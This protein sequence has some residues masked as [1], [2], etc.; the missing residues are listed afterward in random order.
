MF[1]SGGRLKRRAVLLVTVITLLIAGLAM[2]KMACK[3]LFGQINRNYLD[4]RGMQ[5]SYHEL[6]VNGLKTLHIEGLS[7]VF[8]ADT[9]IYC[10][11]LL[12]NPSLKTVFTGKLHLRR[13]TLEGSR[14]LLPFDSLISPDSTDRETKL[15]NHSRKDIPGLIAK[16]LRSTRPDRI[17]FARLEEVTVE[18]VKNNDTSYFFV[19]LAEKR[20]HHFDATVVSGS[21]PAKQNSF[22]ISGEIYNNDIQLYV[23][24]SGQALIFFPFLQNLTGT[25][26][27]FDSLFGRVLLSTEGKLSRMDIEGGLYNSRWVNRRLSNEVVRFDTLSLRM[28][29]SFAPGWAEMDSLGYCNV[30]GIVF[31]PYIRY[32]HRQEDSLTVRLL[33]TVWEANRFFSRLPEGLFDEVRQVKARGQMLFYM[34]FAVNLQQPESIHFDMQLRGRGLQFFGGLGQFTRLRESFVHRVY[35]KGLFVKDIT[36][37]PE[38]PAYVPLHA[39]SPYLKYA[40]LTSE[41]GGFYQHAGFNTE[42]FAGAIAQNIREKRFARGGS[43]I[44]MQLVK[45]LYLNRNKNIF[46]KVEEALIV[47]IIERNRLVSKDRLLEVYFNIIEWGPGVYGIGPATEFYFSKPPS[48]LTLSESVFL[49]SIVP[50]P[51]AFRY[52]FEANGRL[53]PFFTSYYHLVTGI[54]VRR[55]QLTSADTVGGQQPIWLQGG[56]EAWLEAADTIAVDTFAVEDYEPFGVVDTLGWK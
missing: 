12:V 16:L 25:R 20:R 9:L 45:N 47:W 17:R 7:L 32:S 54:M 56:A 31:R 36:V 46:R 43:T 35:D 28:G 15:V 8:G 1:S 3:W 37:G 27:G 11:E 44:S 50:R 6:N 33:P 34:D 38:N 18:I 49:A 40:V 2:R 55:N 48:Q 23:H 14:I 42:A 52:S 53:K 26:V 51:K 10:R 22:T 29:L 39:I 21:E 5:L 24:N 4:A 13:C 41:D 19:P 30:N